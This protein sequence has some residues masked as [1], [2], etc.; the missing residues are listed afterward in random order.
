MKKPLFV[1]ILLCFSLFSFA[2]DF[3]VSFQ[4]AN[5]TSAIDS[6]WVTNLTTGQ[7]VK[8]PGNE[9]LF[10]SLVTGTKIAVLPEKSSFIYPNPCQGD[11]FLSIGISASQKV[12]VRVYSISG[13]LLSRKKADL[14]AGQHYFQV[15]FPDEGIYNVSVLKDDGNLGFKAISSGVKHQAGKIEY[16]GNANKE[17]MKNA[18]LLKSLGFKPGDQL[19]FSLFSG[20][21]N[22]II[23]DSPTAQ[24]AYSVEFQECIDSEKQSYP[25]VKIGT[26][27][28]MAENLK[29]TK[30]R[31]G[32]E[33]PLVTADAA[34]SVL[35]TGAYCWYSN[36]VVNKS[37]YGAMYNWYAVTDSHKLCPDEW[38][39]PE[40]SEWKTL[41]M[42]LELSQT[43]ANA[44][45]WR[46]ATLGTR[47][48][49]TTGWDHANGTNASG[50]SALPGGFRYNGGK[51]YVAG[52][53]GYWWTASEYPPNPSAWYR[54]VSD[55]VGGIYRDHNG[56]NFGFNVRCVKN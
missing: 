17:T 1:A 49:A 13:Q 56:N 22:T 20:K 50:F 7:K 18:T 43:Q 3:T 5:G 36:N 34:W 45:D 8:L 4:S 55:P 37:V 9:S 54:S 28:W 47:C 41:E 14:Q 12:E 10:L 51:F 16:A 38:H 27:W 32:T 29:S 44:S 52:H 46:G 48:K 21:N 30:Y 42:T 15:F 24:R 53:D 25:V 39:I 2:S 35:T 19:L 26:Q 40:D 33:I 6:I 23:T 31:D 11:A